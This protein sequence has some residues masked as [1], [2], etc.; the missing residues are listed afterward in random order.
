VW[1]TPR[2]QAG[3]LKACYGLCGLLAVVGLTGLVTMR[4]LG[5]A[6]EVQRVIAAEDRMYE[7]RVAAGSVTANEHKRLQR[8]APESESDAN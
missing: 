4:S 1:T 5:S 6:D 8:D 3:A 7:A 2:S